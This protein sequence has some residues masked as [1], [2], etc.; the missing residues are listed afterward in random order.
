MIDDEVTIEPW[1]P[2]NPYPYYD[3]HQVKAFYIK[4]EAFDCS[5]ASKDLKDTE[6]EEKKKKGK[7]FKKNL[8]VLPTQPIPSQEIVAMPM[9]KIGAPG[10]KKQIIK[11]PHVCHAC[12]VAYVNIVDLNSH[13]ASH[14]G[15][16]YKCPKCDET[17][18]MENSLKNHRRAEDSGKLYTC[19]QC[20]KSFQLQTSLLNH[21]KT[22]STALSACQVFS[23]CG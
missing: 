20:G 15:F 21:V 22:H 13:I 23:T 5:T 3:K 17:F 10:K 19:Q 4:E 8:P 6:K 1:D 14:E 2:Y 18:R 7:K 12:K 9:G 16:T 11:D